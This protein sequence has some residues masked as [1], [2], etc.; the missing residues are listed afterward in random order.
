MPPGVLVERDGS[1]VVMR[2][3]AIGARR[4]GVDIVA[5]GSDTASKIHAANL[6]LT[7]AERMPFAML[8]DPK[9]E[10]FK[11]WRCHDDFE[12]MPLHG[13]FLVDK[14]GRVRWQ[15]ISYE[16]FTKLDWLLEESRRLLALP[17]SEA[18][19]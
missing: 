10:A 8:A 9:L 16:P 13:T 18:I 7:A 19:R 15:D 4:I 6:D 1:G 11:A 5:I 2:G 12:G 17:A 14:H 3:R